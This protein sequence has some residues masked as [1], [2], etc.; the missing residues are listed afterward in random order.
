M[1]SKKNATF[2]LR[3]L[4]LSIQLN[5][6]YAKSISSRRLAFDTEPCTTEAI[7]NERY[8]IMKNAG[9]IDG[10]F[11]S[12]EDFSTYGC[13]LRGENVYFGLG[14]TFDDMMVSDLPGTRERVWCIAEEETSV[15]S[16]EG[17]SMSMATSISSMEMESM[18]M[19]TV[20]ESMSTRASN[21]WLRQREDVH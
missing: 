19:V 11:Y 12:S 17:M 21:R 8:M 20:L 15:G 6:G 13:F 1:P 4:L 9:L 2:C 14:G 18:S 7:C 16:S 5:V 3:M 10:H